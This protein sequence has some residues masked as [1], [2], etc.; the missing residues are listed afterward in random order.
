M[1]CTSVVHPVRLQGAEL[2]VFLEGKFYHVMSGK[3][4]TAVPQL[5]ATEVSSTRISVGAV[6]VLTAVEEGQDIM[7]GTDWPKESSGRLTNTIKK[8]GAMKH[9]L[10]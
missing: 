7:G 8:Q 1:N 6:E 10:W 3:S 4:S 2:H 9:L 5:D